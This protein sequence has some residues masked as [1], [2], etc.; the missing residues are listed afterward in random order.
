MYTYSPK[1]YPLMKI[2]W[3]PVLLKS[4]TYARFK[5]V[6]GARPSQQNGSRHHLRATILRAGAGGDLSPGRTKARV[7]VLERMLSDCELRLLR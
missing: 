2:M 3:I 7:A 4:A 1:F 5:M 6:A